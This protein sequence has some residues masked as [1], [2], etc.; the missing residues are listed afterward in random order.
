MS[1]APTPE[2]RAR[3]LRA[4]L[5]ICSA[6]TPGPWPHYTVEAAAA[7]G[8]PPYGDVPTLPRVH[9]DRN[10]WLRPEDAVFIGTARTALPAALRRLIHLETVIRDAHSQ[11][12]D[13]CCWM[14]VDRIFAAI[15]LPVPDRRVGD[16][17]AMLA[18]CG[19]FLDV[20]CSS[21]HW[22]SYADLE[23]EIEQMRTLNSRYRE[24]LE[25]IAAL[26]ST[27]V[28]SHEEDAGDMAVIAGLTLNTPGWQATGLTLESYLQQ[29][30]AKGFRPGAR[31]NR[32]GG[33]ITAFWDNARSVS[34]VISADLTVHR[35]EQGGHIT[36]CTIGPS[37]CGE[38]DFHR[39]REAEQ[40]MKDLEAEAERLRAEN[41]R[42]QAEN[43]QLQPRPW[44]CE[45]CGGTLWDAASCGV[46]SGKRCRGCGYIDY[47][48]DIP[49]R[50]ELRR[51]IEKLKGKG[52][53]PEHPALRPPQQ[54]QG[55]AEQ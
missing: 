48:E 16:K 23:R 37:V 54:E 3:D 34:E 19:R 31:Y 38:L 8:P 46:A 10:E 53:G 36:G 1:I 29:R 26:P 47:D 11:R 32:G 28:N 39:R 2:D 20:L 12:A 15:G 27:S 44:A 35:A 21:G 50:A 24:G 18:N 30:A 13:D 55:S 40:R 7:S 14:D 51:G 17:A 49:D 45:K 22:P 6:A 42:L 41:A 9:H 43:I 4:D 25:Q 52:D 33:S 5:A